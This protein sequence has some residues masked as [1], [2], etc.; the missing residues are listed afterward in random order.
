MTV[1]Q[2]RSVHYLTQTQTELDVW[3]GDMDTFYT[4]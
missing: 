4:T 1:L 3:L 2:G